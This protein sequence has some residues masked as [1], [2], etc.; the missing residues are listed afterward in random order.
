MNFYPLFLV[1]GVVMTLPAHINIVEVG[2][3]DGLQD[4]KKILSVEKRIQFIDYLSNCGFTNIEVGSF[5]PEKV[6]PQMHNAGQVLQK[7]KRHKGTTYSALVPNLYGL[8]MALEAQVDMVAVF[9]AASESF[10]KNNINCSIFESLKRYEEVIVEAKNNSIP[11]RGY[12]SC[13]FSCPYEGDIPEHIVVQYCKKLY[14]LGCDEIALGDTTGLGTPSKVAS[15]IGNLSDFLPREKITLHLHNSNGL[16]LTNIY[17]AMKEGVTSFDSSIAG[18]GGCP[19]AKNA[20]GNVASEDLVYL[21]DSLKVK[22]GLSLETLVKTSTFI[23]NLLGRQSN[24][25]IT[26]LSKVTDL[27]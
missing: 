19:F 18:L 15:L 26:N 5:V 9:M 8:K 22:T 7:I 23:C 3:R 20:T 14:E 2:P 16:A 21:L 1:L 11:V 6:V 17:V 27:K 10:S 24:S 25:C 12:L 13:V 4:E